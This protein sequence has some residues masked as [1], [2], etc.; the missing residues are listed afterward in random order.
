MAE[1]HRFVIEDW[2][3][4]EVWCE[5]QSNPNSILVDVRTLP[6]WSFVGVPDLTELGKQV[7]FAEWRS[8]PHLH[9]NPDFLD[10]V[11]SRTDPDSLDT[12][13][14]I[15]RSGQRSRDA[16]IAFAERSRASGRE[17]R[18]V[19]VAEGFEGVL[20]AGSRRGRVNGWKFR[21]LAWKQS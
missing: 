17:T 7:I 16:A 1:A 18:C 15:C 8:Y 9:P 11:E 14:F 5:L 12:V 13:F 4:N 3:P 20:D 2:P 21:G 6:E 10:Q 19:N